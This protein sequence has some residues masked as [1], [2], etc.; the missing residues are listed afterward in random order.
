[1]T[2]YTR[3]LQQLVV[4]IKD[5][6]GDTSIS[7]DTRLIVLFLAGFMSNLKFNA[8]IDRVQQ[9]DH[10]NAKYKEINSL[11]NILGN[12][13]YEYILLSIVKILDHDL[14]SDELQQF[15]GDSSEIADNHNIEPALTAS[16]L[17][18]PP[19]D[20]VDATQIAAK[21]LIK[22]LESIETPSITTLLDAYVHCRQLLDPSTAYH[23]LESAIMEILVCGGLSEPEAHD[24]SSKLVAS[25]LGDLIASTG[26]DRGM[27]NAYKQG[28][29][30]R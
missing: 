24:Y 27:L 23:A 20:I 22:K 13:C 5:I 10:L 26:Q 28:I 6:F 16:N 2:K 25:S 7:I 11:N 14:N 18:V 19:E 30:L 9:L 21:V 1:M 29:V 15:I 4:C 8:W 12:F 17:A 3:S